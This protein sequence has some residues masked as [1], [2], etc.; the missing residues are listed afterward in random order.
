MGY[1]VISLYSMH[2]VFHLR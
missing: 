2:L 1:A